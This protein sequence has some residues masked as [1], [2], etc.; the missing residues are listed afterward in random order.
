LDGIDYTFGNKRA[1][2][3]IP[4]VI[5]KI[6]FNRDKEGSTKSL[7]ERTGSNSQTS[8]DSP[9]NLELKRSGILIDS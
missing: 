3:G 7:L 2:T 1:S 4:Y 6:K 8:K 5:P 9:H